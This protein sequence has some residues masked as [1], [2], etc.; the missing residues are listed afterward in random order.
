MKIPSINNSIN[1]GKKAVLNCT[2][3][4]KRNEKQDATLYELD[5]KNY[6]DRELVKNEYMLA[7]FKG[8]F[9]RYSKNADGMKF[10][11][12]EN[13]LNNEV[14]SCAQT[15]RHVK[16][17]DKDNCGFFTSLDEISGDNFYINPTL[18]IIGQIIKDSTEHYCASIV[19]ANSEDEGEDLKKYKFSKNKYG[20][21]VLPDKRFSTVE[22][23][24]AK[25]NQI[26][27][28]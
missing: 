24:A 9:L 19:S 21:F 3:K 1:F 10:Y 4:N 14:V 11:V 26:E 5:N 22:D 25:R 15:S 6:D 17:Y 20:D 23:M 16:L 18:P 8:D 2:I 28:L 27:Y 12:L 13:N 7:R